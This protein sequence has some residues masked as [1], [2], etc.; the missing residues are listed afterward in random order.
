M[1]VVACG[2]EPKDRDVPVSP[3]PMCCVCVCVLGGSR[4]LMSRV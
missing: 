3:L 4:G 2:K 1:Q